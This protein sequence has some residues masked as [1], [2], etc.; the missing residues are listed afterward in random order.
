MLWTG[1]YRQ[2]WHVIIL[3]E[4]PLIE[5]RWPNQDIPDQPCRDREDTKQIAMFVPFCERQP[6]CNA[7]IS[8]YSYRKSHKHS[9]STEMSAPA[10]TFLPADYISWQAI[11]NTQ[12]IILGEII[13]SLPILVHQDNNIK[14]PVG[15]NSREN[16]CDPQN[17][18]PHYLEISCA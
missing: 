8:W 13:Y 9:F 15:V 18:D 3:F 11:E 12:F 6:C 16:S 5:K 2:Y 1:H 10:E 7:H 4:F 17:N 14:F